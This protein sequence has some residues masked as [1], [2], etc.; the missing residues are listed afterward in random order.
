MGYLATSPWIRRRTALCAYG[1]ACLLSLT[2]VQPAIAARS[3]PE[4]AFYS[5]KPIAFEDLSAFTKWNDLWPRYEEQHEAALDACGDDETCA[6]RQWETLL[7]SLEDKPLREQMAVI[8]A[9][10]NAVPYIEDSS[11]FGMDDYWQ[12]PYE[13]MNSGGDCE[14]YAIAK[15]ISLKRL[16]VPESAMR[17]MIVQDQNLGGI[18][19]AVLEVRHDGQ[20]YVLDNQASTVTRQRDIFHYR[21]IYAINSA[22]WWA[23]Q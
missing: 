12:T 5:T 22:N 9:H 10:F 4:N 20:R 21:P 16:G 14:D 11:N 23:Y 6:A 13:F 17:I 3:T 2:S 8:N 18:M 15:Y 1:M 19:H 7:E